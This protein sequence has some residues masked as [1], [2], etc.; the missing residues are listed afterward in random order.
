MAVKV[1]RTDQELFEIG[2]LTVDHNVW[3]KGN[4][5]AVSLGYKRP[6]DAVRNHVDDE[7]KKTYEALVQGGVNLTPPSNQQPTEVYVNE[8]GLYSLVMRSKTP[9]AHAS[10]RWVTSVVLPC[11]RRTG[12]Y[13]A[14][15]IPPELTTAISE[16]QQSVR[17]LKSSS[18][19]GVQHTAICLSTPQA[20]KEEKRMLKYGK[21]L[22][23]QELTQLNE[24]ESV[25]QL[26]AWL[27]SKVKATNPEAKRKILY[28]FRTQAKEARLS[29]A[30][31]DDNKVPLTWMQGGHRIVWTNTTMSCSAGSSTICSPSS[32]P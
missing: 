13:G 28:A 26:S 32:K 7:D 20:S 19:S 11:I 14:P 10:Q 18:S 15:I 27:D 24:S 2:A 25:V 3:F 4:D 21:V 17:D 8:S 22:S 31:I 29:Q 6:H 30:E 5:I 23:T 16:L 1:S 9:S 12:S